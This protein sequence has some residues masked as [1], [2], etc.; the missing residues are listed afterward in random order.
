MTD[1]STPWPDVP[2]STFD[3]DVPISVALQFKVTSAAWLKGFRF[4]RG[5]TDILGPV[6]AE[7]FRVDG[8][9]VGTAIPATDVTYGL[10]GVGWQTVLLPTPYLLTV[11]QD[12]KGVHH[13]PTNYTATGGYFTGGLGSAGFV[14][15]PLTVFSAAGSTEG[16][17][18]FTAGAAITYPVSTFNGGNFWVDVIVT[19]SIAPPAPITAFTGGNGDCDCFVCYGAC[20]VTP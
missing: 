3:A 20:A 6:E 14:N 8:A 16:Q 9:G 10:S 5:T 11:G 2:P 4:W 17:D 15:G 18:T 1:Y 19:D 12:Y 13:F 7:L